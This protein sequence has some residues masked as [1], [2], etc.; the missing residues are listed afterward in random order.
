MVDVGSFQR[1]EGV[2]MP[3]VHVKIEQLLNIQVEWERGGG[4][5]LIN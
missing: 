5:C 1:G 4:T 2:G 3:G